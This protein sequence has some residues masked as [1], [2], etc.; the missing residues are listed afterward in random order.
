[1][2][3]FVFHVRI[4]HWNGL[5]QTWISCFL[6]CLGNLTH[7]RLTLMPTWVIYLFVLFSKGSQIFSINIPQEKKIV[8][9]FTFLLLLT[10]FLL[11]STW[12]VPLKILM[13]EI[14]HLI[15][16]SLFFFLPAELTLKKKTH[17]FSYTD[18][19]VSYFPFV[20]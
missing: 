20:L 1:M 3:F 18:S 15:S 8:F 10:I 12:S 13:K 4:W 17:V 2:F 9:L 5:G 16:F 11:F 14:F 7:F 19:G 6:F